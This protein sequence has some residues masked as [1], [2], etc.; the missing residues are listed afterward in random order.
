MTDLYA[1]Q[2]EL[3][4]VLTAES[5]RSLRE[6]LTSAL[7]GTPTGQGPI[8]DVGAGT[9]FGVEV[10]A[11]VLPDARI[12]AI[13]P[14][15]SLRPGL[16]TRIMLRPGLRERVTVLPTD[17][18]GAPLPD[19][20][21]GVV[22][23]NMVGH[24]P[25]AQRHALWQVLGTRLAPGAPVVIG[26]QPPEQPASVP[27]MRFA[28]VKVGVRTYEGWGSAEPSGS[29]TVRWHMRFRVLHGEQL[30]EE[31]AA[32]YQ[33]WTISEADL[34]RELAEVGLRTSRGGAGLMVARS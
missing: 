30:L 5:W 7:R 18:A 28:R 21:G 1:A 3:Y 25:P 9:G 26:L 17:V 4:D 2:G 29:D 31:R 15:L 33:W 10:I 8:L 13:E 24:L 6:P 32:S 22:A 16:F 11:D 19:R 12:L 23:L 20:L 27:D 14:S 34:T